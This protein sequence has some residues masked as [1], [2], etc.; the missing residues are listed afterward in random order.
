MPFTVKA[1]YRSETRKLSF[2]EC[3]S[4][5]SFDQLYHQL[6]R[7]FPISHS[8]VLSK[9]LFSPDSSDS[10]VLLSREVRNAAEYDLAV[11]PFKGRAWMGP[12]LRVSVSDETPHKL[13]SSPHTWQPQ[14]SN[15]Q[16]PIVSNPFPVVEPSFGRISYSHIPPPPIIFSSR[17]CP[18]EPMDVGKPETNDPPTVPQHDIA[19]CCVVA[20]TRKD[21]QELI[22]SFKV[23]LDRVIASLEPSPQND[24]PMPLNQVPHSEDSI[25]LP[26]IPLQVPP[27][28]VPE[29]SSTLSLPSVPMHPPLCQYNLCWRCGVIKQGPW[30]DCSTCNNKLCVTCLETTSIS[31]CFF[32]SP[33]VWK[34]QTC[35]YCAPNST[36]TPTPSPLQPTSWGSVP[37]TFG[38]LLLPS[39]PTMAPVLREDVAP[40]MPV[41]HTVPFALPVGENESA[42]N[43]NG[44]VVHHGVSCDSCRSIIEGVR[45]KCLDCP[46]YDLCSSCIANGAAARHTPFHEFFEI[47]EPGRVVVHN[48]FSGSGEREAAPP[49]R[50]NG[51]PVQSSQPVVHNA[52]CDLCESRIRGDRYKCINCPDWDCCANCFTITNEHHPRHAFVK[53]SRPED[54]IRR[55]QTPVREHFATCDSCSRRI[56]GIRYKCM[57]QDCPDFDLCSACEALPIAVHPATHPLLKVKDVGTALP[58]V[59]RNNVGEFRPPANDIATSA[60]DRSPIEAAPASLRAPSPAGSYGSGCL[61]NPA[62]GTHGI[63]SP[64]AQPPSP[65]YF[66][67][68][69]ARSQTPE[70]EVENTSLPAPA[71]VRNFSPVPTR[72]PS[73]TMMIPGAMPTFFNLPPIESLSLSTM[74][75]TSPPI[76]LPPI[77]SKPL[78]HESI[79]TPSPLWKHTPYAR[80]RS[81]FV[82]PGEYMSESQRAPARSPSP[83]R[84]CDYPVMAPSGVD[85]NTISSQNSPDWGR[86]HG[87][88]NPF[89]VRIPSHPSSNIS[90]REHSPIHVLPPVPSSTVASG[91]W[92]ENFQEIRHLMDDEPS[93]SRDLRR[94][95]AQSTGSGIPAEESSIVGEREPLL[96]RPASSNSLSESERS[97]R[98]LAS[99]LSGIN[100]PATNPFI[101]AMESKEALIGTP[102]APVPP[103]VSL[104]STPSTLNTPNAEFVADRNIVDGQVVAPGAEFLK[105]WVMRNGGS[106]PWP[107]GTELVFVAGESFAKDNTTIQPQ[108]VGV[109]QPNEQIELWTGEL[110]APENPGRYVA[111]YR[112][113]DGEGNLF[114]HSIWLDI[115]VSEAFQRDS[116]ETLASSDYLSSSS[117]IIMP[118]AASTPSSAVANN[119]AN[120]NGA[121]EGLH[122]NSSIPGSPVTALSAPSVS[123]Y[124]ET[125]D[126][127]SE[128]SGSL[129]DVTDSDSDEELWQDSRT[130]VLVE[131]H[132]A[133]SQATIRATTLPDEY[134]VLYDEATSSEEE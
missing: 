114:G 11:A 101:T 131:G 87:N 45:H 19:S 69:S 96:S 2:P 102:S 88:G 73:P 30:F 66:R 55:D 72:S 38:S 132:G 60:S 4:F 65:F 83:E 121:P 128:T 36:P 129:L 20:Q 97:V 35:S 107:E 51:S 61:R 115:T 49:M 8:I 75:R 106:R 108:S 63:P 118:T 52:V 59:H 44:R 17:P 81:P 22:T 78:V 79:R 95:M 26:K 89:L 3:D 40:E 14:A 13:P 103:V 125:S 71:P 18:Q 12:S 57:H 48:V 98:S 7:V 85:Y 5:P 43:E 23:D 56:F 120:R 134:V 9:L 47:S 29:S 82:I 37:L 94:S 109:V 127:D 24:I 64:E 15:P 133:E 34:K 70:S 1:T 32:G 6:Y 74:L 126:N 113:R 110:K 117:I 123:D 86:V 104:P 84:T 41:P 80:P 122:R 16:K 21:V 76:T 39:V 67:S 28:N 10:R 130:S 93:F 116:P 25:Q 124:V 27:S 111:Y 46:D 77:Q 58:T 92:P 100:M 42:R 33:H 90:R 53:V 54:F 68:Q 62:V 31:D 112:L 119:D 99:I 91:F 105:A 50:H